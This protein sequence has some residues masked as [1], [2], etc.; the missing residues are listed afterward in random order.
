MVRERLRFTLVR[1]CERDLVAITGTGY[2][3]NYHFG[4]KEG[5]YRAVLET[6]L[7]ALIRRLNRARARSRSGAA[8]SRSRSSH[9]LLRPI[10]RPG[11]QHKAS[12]QRRAATNPR[13]GMATRS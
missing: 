11:R 10:L 6:A 13:H 3:Q 12:R 4:S 1:L 8:E 2:V 5:L 9:R 7:R